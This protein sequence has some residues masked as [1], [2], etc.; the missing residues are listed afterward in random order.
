M[1]RWNTSQPVSRQHFDAGVP[2]F[3]SPAATLTICLTVFGVLHAVATASA[4][5][6][7]I[8]GLLVVNALVYVAAALLATFAWRARSSVRCLR[9]ARYANNL[10]IAGLIMTIVGTCCLVLVIAI[11]A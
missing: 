4:E 1:N 9:F 10:S 11:R 5:R 2:I 6:V 7:A 3:V 8:D